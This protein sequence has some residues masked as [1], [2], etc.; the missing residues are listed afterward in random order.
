DLVR[1]VVEL[2]Q[3]KLKDAEKRVK[4]SAPHQIVLLAL[5]DLAEE[6]VTARKRTG[7]FKKKVDEKS[8]L[9]LGLI[10]AELE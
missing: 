2:V 5:L 10:E 9:L 6:Y 3:A 7:E 1:D 4:G 8:Q